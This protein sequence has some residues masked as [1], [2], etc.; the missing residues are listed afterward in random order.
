MCIQNELMRDYRYLVVELELNLFFFL[1]F[2]FASDA[3][4]ATANY[5]AFCLSRKKW[6]FS[7]KKKMVQKTSV[8]SLFC[9]SFRNAY[10]ENKIRGEKKKE[11]K[12]NK[13]TKITEFF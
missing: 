10:V 3:N 6:K 9:N 1:Y 12:N 2:L 11:Q 7:E 8:V 5:V 4:P 13:N